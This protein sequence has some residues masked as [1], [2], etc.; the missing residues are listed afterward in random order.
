[1]L[2]ALCLAA[3]LAAPHKVI[4][5]SWDGAPH[6]VVSRMIA[7]G[8]LPTLAA[9]AKEGVM[10]DGMLAAYPSKTAVGHA[11]IYNGC[12]PDRTGVSNNTVPQMP[13][14]EHTPFET[15][16]GFDSAALKTEPLMITA[17]RQGKRVVSL[18]STQSFPTERWTELLREEGRE[19]NLTTFSGFESQIVGNRSLTA[20]D[21]RP[22]PAWPNARAVGQ[23]IQAEAQVGD[24][25]F[26]FQAIDDA[27]DPAV[28]FDTVLLREKGT[29]A[30]ES[31]KP[32]EA[33]EDT[34]PWSKPHRV[35][36]GDWFGNAFF[37]LFELGSDGKAVTLFI[38]GA[39]A[40]RGTAG[41]AETEEYLKAYPGFHADAFGDYERGALGTPLYKGGDGL[42]E[43]RVLE[44]VRL[45]CEF[46]TSSTLYAAKR[47]SPD[48]ITH[49][50]PQSDSAG[51]TWMGLLD[52]GTPAYRPELAAKL[53]PI[54][55]K[56]L[57]LQDAWIGNVRAALGKEYAV[58]IV[59][60]H[61]MEGVA[62]R[63]RPNVVLR[64]AGLL[65]VEGNRVDGS[66]S[67]CF[68]P[69]WGEFSPI[70]HTTDWKGGIVPPSE[71][72]TVMDQAAKALLSARDP[73]T[74]DPIVTAVFRADDFAQLGIGGDTAGDLYL[75]LAPGY[76]PVSEASGP[77]VS[78]YDRE[79]GGGAHGFFPFR[80]KMQAIFVAAGPGVG[81][82]TALGGVR[83]V[84]VNPTVCALLGI[85]AA[86]Q[87]V[88]RSLFD[89]PG[90]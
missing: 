49:Y 43:R 89:S 85:R 33:G 28:G 73:E 13:R 54:Y 84:D 50:T 36:K 46:L 76:Y 47:Y 41:V 42:A 82:R 9:M 2:T 25:T 60:D 19:A 10:A 44:L 77:I 48:L 57:Q 1:M 35:T 30:M 51:H 29:T 63:F 8:K 31:L 61:G 79:R 66:R 7:E 80:R 62:K 23:A 18:S 15:I 78:V 90:R 81:A 58:V 71:K 45:D 4:L 39:A 34:R 55:E 24:Q 72:A 3:T 5:V 14:A 59:S 21:F 52:P 17:A 86:P 68:A 70:V 22:A 75:D 64:E 53:W 88:G 37:R 12:W 67:K 6:W 26:E 40:M 56:V 69:P 27:N 20:K 83:Q 87:V 74:G 38:R 32:R 16:R 11:A 65:T